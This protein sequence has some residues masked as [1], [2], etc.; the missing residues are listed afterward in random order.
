MPVVTVDREDPRFP[1]L[2]KGHNLRF[3]ATE[4][5]AASH[6][7]LCT[8][9]ADCASALQRIVSAGIRPTIRSGGHCYEDDSPRQGCPLSCSRA[10]RDR[11]CAIHSSGSISAFWNE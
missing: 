9:A 1:A 8:D 6:I 11:W 4:A 10:T 2:E 5:E 3:P 7:V